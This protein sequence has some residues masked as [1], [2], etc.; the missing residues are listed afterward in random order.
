MEIPEETGSNYSRTVSEG[1]GGVFVLSPESDI[2][3]LSVYEY[4][5]G[6]FL[7]TVV[8]KYQFKPQREY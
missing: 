5:D 4:A 6:Y 7:P 1:Q 3:I 2:G 8:C